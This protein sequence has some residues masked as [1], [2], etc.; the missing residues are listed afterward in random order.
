[1]VEVIV[2]LAE[3]PKA[4]GQVF[5][6]GSTTE[7]TIR[8][9]AERVLA[10]TGSQSEIQYVP[11]DMAYA[12]GFEDMRRRVPSIEKISRMIG[13]T[14]RFS[15]DEALKRVVEYEKAQLEL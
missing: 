13:Y 7:V 3:H 1:M 8:E 6:I 10:I 14:P 15:L 4:L 9:L 5:N 12:P 11:Y 2:E